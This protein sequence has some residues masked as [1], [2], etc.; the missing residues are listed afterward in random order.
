MFDL[1]PPFAD[2]P[3]SA[4]DLEGTSF[5][6]RFLFPSSVLVVAPPTVAGWTDSALSSDLTLV[7]SFSS[8]APASWS[9]PLFLLFFR[10]CF[11]FFLGFS[12]VGSPSPSAAVPFSFSLCFECLD[13]F[14]C[15]FFFF[16]FLA[17]PPAVFSS[18]PSD[19]TGSSFGTAFSLS[20]LVPGLLEESALIVDAVA[21]CT[22]S[23][24]ASGLGDFDSFAFRTPLLRD[25]L[26]SKYRGLQL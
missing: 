1:S 23:S 24:D 11:F 9:G 3:S 4:P 19:F 21:S 10:L 12:C 5:V 18:S 26:K 16:F 20:V 14:L 15:F 2:P 6:A 8:P 22:F 25:N 17:T 7:L 13:D